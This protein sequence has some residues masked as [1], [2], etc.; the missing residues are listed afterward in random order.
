MSSV[1]RHLFVPENVREYA[2]SD[3]PLPIGLG[4]TI[5]QPY[6]VALMTE[7]LAAGK[8]DG[9]LEIGTGS[10]YQAAILAGNAKHVYTIE[11]VPELAKSAQERLAAMGAKN[12]T[13]RLGDGYKSVTARQHS[14]WWCW[15]RPPAVRSAAGRWRR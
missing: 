13:V 10:G 12:I 11:I 4:Q 3:R 5:S 8:T 1:P 2:Y 7:L 14:N 9:V 6:I 15:K